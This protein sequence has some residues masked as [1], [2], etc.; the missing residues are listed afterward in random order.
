M[1]RKPIGVIT[2]GTT[3]P[4]RLRRVDRFIA[5]QAVMR[6]ALNPVVVDLGFGA[7]PT[8]TIEL[9]ARLEKVNPAT[10]VVG[11][12]INRERVA[13]ALPFETENLRFIFGGF[14]IPL[15]EWG[16]EKVSVIRVM[17][18][19]RQYEESEVLPAWQLM[20]SRLSDSGII[21]EGTCD[22]I[23]RLASWI[24]L[25]SNG[26][27]TLTLSYRL[28]SVTEPSKIAERLPKALI[29]HN[30]PG[31]PINKLL[32]DLDR[33]WA[34]HSALAVFSPVQRFRKTCEALIQN[35][36]PLAFEPKRWRLGELSVDWNAVKS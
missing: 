5:N 34:A 29:H 21:V 16:V 2:R 6:E 10:R 32:S 4:N 36:W 31:T 28:S 17:N 1:P 25:D 22:E 20:Q 26:P 18:V 24:T 35:G 3:N 33:A 27:K 8:T 7:N 19:L 9:L 14:E 30:I 13:T 11:I 23:G 12:E 15:P